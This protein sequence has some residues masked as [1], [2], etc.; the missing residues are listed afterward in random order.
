MADPVYYDVKVKAIFY[1]ANI[2]FMPG[3]PYTVSD[4]IYNSSLTDGR[5]FA[6]LCESATQARPAE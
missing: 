1:T 2:E 6:D 3:I 4:E 5:K